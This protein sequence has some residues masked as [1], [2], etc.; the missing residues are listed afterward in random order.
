MMNRDQTKLFITM[1]LNTAVL[2][3]H[4]AQSEHA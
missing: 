1:R 4:T 3:Q 2:Q